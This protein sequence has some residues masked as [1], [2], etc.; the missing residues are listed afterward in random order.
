VIERYDLHVHTRLSPCAHPEMR[1]KAIL[2]QCA[3]RGVRHLGITDH[4]GAS[5][6]PAILLEVR[7]E[8]EALD[9]PMCVFVGCEADILAVGK[10]MVTDV[11]R[12]RVDFVAVAANHFHVPTV[13]QPKDSSPESLRMLYLDMFRY[14]CTL[15]FADVIVHPMTVLLGR[16]DPALLDP[17]SDDDLTGAIETARDNAIAMEISPRALLPGQMEFRLRFLKLC[18]R[19][20]VKFSIGT[21]SHRLEQV[22]RGDLMQGLVDELG[23]VESDI[24]APGDR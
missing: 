19:I 4:I 20:G 21:D 2:Q 18:K 15:D 23:I 24:W 12:S 11:V 5:T 1:I 22:G 17:I 8:L 7:S 9:A 10:H 16:Y 6:D 14:A 3:C 13:Q